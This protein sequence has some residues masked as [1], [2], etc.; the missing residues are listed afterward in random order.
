MNCL[1]LMGFRNG[2][3][4]LCLTLFF[5][6]VMKGVFVL[7]AED[8]ADDR[9]LLQSAF[10]ENKFFDTLT[11]VENGIEMMAILNNLVDLGITS[12]LPSFIMLD[13]NM[14][15]KDGREVLKDIKSKPLLRTIPVIIFSTTNNETEM[16]RCYDMGANSYITKPASFDGLI[17]TIAAIRSQWVIR[18]EN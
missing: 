4:N 9:F 3:S 17:K 16:R 5:V 7:I 14:P 8:D 15:K 6:M 13:L 2:I 10:E 18:S 12:N 11:F 1:N